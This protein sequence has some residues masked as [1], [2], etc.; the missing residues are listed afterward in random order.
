[1]TKQI[2]ITIDREYGSGGRYISNVLSKLY[3]INVY[4]HNM[5]SLIAQEKGLNLDELKKFDEKKRNIWFTRSVDGFSNSPE[6]NV[7]QMQFDFLKEKA[8]AGESFIALGRCGNY[9]LRNYSNV[10]RIFITGDLEKR[11]E[12]IA[13]TKEMSLAKAEVFV[14]KENK[15]R[16]N[17]H[18]YYSKQKWGDSRHY[19][20]IVNAS[21]IGLDNAVEV[22]DRYIKSTENDI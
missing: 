5:L 19:D 15:I 13:E 8:D 17:Y 12:R 14:E 3:G 9:I 20:L 7:A 6:D 18:N 16:K 1:M 4:G 11:I 22:I 2:I 21:K 10:V